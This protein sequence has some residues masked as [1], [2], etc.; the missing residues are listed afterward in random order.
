LENQEKPMPTIFV[1]YRR[2]DS[3]DV[4]GR[5]YDRLVSKFTQKQ[6]FKDVD[7]IPLG[8]SFPAHIRQLLSKASVVLVVIG[9]DWVTAEDEHGRR[10][11]DDPSDFVRL[12]VE[13][14]LRADMPVIPV[15]VSNASMPQVSERRRPFKSS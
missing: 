10:R 15:L 7:S 12:E 13:L 11:L 9:P 6:I 4:T 1:S 14:A 5:I 8:V 2:S 3:Q